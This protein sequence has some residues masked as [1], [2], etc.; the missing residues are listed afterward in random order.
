MSESIQPV[1]ETEPVQTTLDINDLMRI[2]PHRYPFLM[3]D[4]VIDLKRKERIVA[5]KNVTI[6]E[7]FF[8]G[9]FPNFPIM[10]GVLM[11]EAIAQAGGALLLTEIPNREQMLMV[12]TGRST[13]HRSRS[14]GLARHRGSH[15][16]KDF[17]WRQARGRSYRHLPSGAAHGG[18]GQSGGNGRRGVVCI[19]WTC[20]F[21]VGIGIPRYA[22]NDNESY[23]TDADSSHCD[24]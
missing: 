24:R 18:S 22:R 11:V 16:R 21:V 19:L 3:I 12:F 15:G 2:L 5:I 17:R 20:R 10:P 6:N 4:R 23:F 13:A 8:A 9:H 7:P 1:A 14:E